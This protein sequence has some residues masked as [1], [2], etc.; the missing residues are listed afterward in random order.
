MT[1]G[2]GLSSHD[3]AAQRQR[4]TLDSLRLFLAHLGGTVF[5][6]G[7]LIIVMVLAWQEF[8]PLRWRLAWA[9]AAGLGCLGQGWVGWRLGRAPDLAAALPRWL[10]GL[11]AS[12]LLSSAAWGG[13]PWMV[14]QGTSFEL[15]L[16]LAC[17]FNVCIL[18]AGA[19]APGTPGLVLSLALPTSLLSTLT[20]A[21]HA[22]HALQ[23]LSFGLLFGLVSLYGYRM[24]TAYRDTLV[25]RRAAEALSEALRTEQQR[26]S[27]AER[28]RT[29]L[30]E[31]QR[32]MRDMHDGVGSHLIALLRLAESGAS[33]AAMA[34][35]LRGAI[36][37][38]RLTIDSLEPLEHDLATLLATLR[39]RAG[40]Q[41]EGAGLKLDWAM[42]DMPPLPWLEPAQ[43]LQVLRLV[44][45]AITNVVKHAQARTLSVS[46]RPDGDALEVCIAD[47]GCGFDPAAA[48]A[49]H[50]L[51]SM[52][53]RAAD[54]GATLALHSG[55][56][57]GSIVR[58]R[59]PLQR[60]AVFAAQPPAP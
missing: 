1:D 35:L 41:L 15:P 22:G 54:L 5:A 46:A 27:A 31:R 60:C 36:E 55:P 25:S 8:A 10:P 59:L 52:R 16:L 17:A 4:V 12:I 28:E 23:A 34:D 50:G 13:V 30:L 40:R 49:G 44:Q 48:S 53:R 7:L 42:A 26:A 24:Q 21:A 57:R 19:H 18:F 3:L 51:D 11:H 45:E 6:L 37:D 20:V 39:H 43:A 56:G 29:L 47:D 9:S 14:S 2:A 33:G 32:L 58:L 38:L